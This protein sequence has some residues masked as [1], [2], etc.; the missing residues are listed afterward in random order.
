MHTPSGAD[1]Y[2]YWLYDF[3]NDSVTLHI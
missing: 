1:V 2:F 3:I